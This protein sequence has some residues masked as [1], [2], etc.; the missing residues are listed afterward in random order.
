LETQQI[1]PQKHGRKL[2]IQHIRLAHF[3][4]TMYKLHSEEQPGKQDAFQY[5]ASNTVPCSTH[6][7]LTFRL[8]QID[9]GFD[10]M[11]VFSSS[12]HVYAMRL[13]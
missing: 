3:S 4:N 6:R 12:S 1:L 5:Q 10:R 2:C 7:F 9:F 8:V 11:P 13:S